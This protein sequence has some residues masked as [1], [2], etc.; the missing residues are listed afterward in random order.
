MR[1]LA[2]FS[3]SSYCRLGDLFRLFE[4]SLSQKD[5]G[6][7]VFELSL[8]PFVRLRNDGKRAIKVRVRYP[9]LVVRARDSYTTAPTIAK[10]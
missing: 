10:Q 7:R 3:K 9:N 8:A 5:S 6:A 1:L 4:I 2:T